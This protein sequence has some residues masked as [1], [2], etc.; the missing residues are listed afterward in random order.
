MVKKPPLERWQKAHG[1]GPGWLVPFSKPLQV[2]I[3]EEAQRDKDE[4]QEFR[5]GKAKG[6]R[7]RQLRHPPKWHDR[8]EELANKLWLKC[9]PLKDAGIAGII[10]GKINVSK[11]Q[12][13]RFLRAI[14]KS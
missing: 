5:K 6:G 2:I 4:L 14:K 7:E 11:R 1:D 8:A 12:V 3:A 13:Q 10:A 9:P